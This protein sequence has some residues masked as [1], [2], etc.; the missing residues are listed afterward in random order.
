MTKHGS[1]FRYV[2]ITAAVIFTIMAAFS[3]ICL[4]DQVYAES[5]NIHNVTKGTTHETFDNA[6]SAADPG[7]VLE[8]TGDIDAEDTAALKKNL[9]LKLNGHTITSKLTS[10]SMITISSAGNLTVEGEGGSIVSAQR[11]A[12]AFY[13]NK[14]TLSISS[15]TLNGFSI[16]DNGG[17]IRSA[18]DLTIQ[19]STFTGNSSTNTSTS[20]DGRKSL[21]GGA[22]YQYYGTID[23]KNSIFD[24]NSAAECGVALFIR[25]VDKA[26]VTGCTVT[27]NEAATGGGMYIFQ[28]NDYKSVRVTVKDNVVDGN[29][30]VNT[31]FSG[32]GT[33]S[34][35]GGGMFVLTVYE[36]V[37]LIGNT[38]RNNKA[39]DTNRNAYAARGGGLSIVAYGEYQG[40]E[41]GGTVNITGGVIEGNE[42]RMGGG[43]D[44]S[45]HFMSPLRLDNAL[46]TGNSAVRGGGVWLCPQGSM[47][48]FS[49]LGGAVI[50]N[51][52]PED[53]TIKDLQ[54]GWYT[55]YPN[56]DDINHEG[57]DS[58]DLY[59]SGADVGYIKISKRGQGGV[60]VEWYED[61]SDNRSSPGTREFRRYKE[62]YRVLVSEGK[63]EGYPDLFG[64]DDPKG[65]NKSFGIHA[66][67]PYVTSKE[68]FLKELEKEAHLIIRNNYALRGGGIAANSPV[69]M[70][71]KD[72]P[73]RTLKVE[74]KWADDK[75]L[76]NEIRIDLV[77]YDTDE[78]GTPL[79]DEDGGL[80][81]RTLLDRDLVLSSDNDWSRTF[82]DLPYK[83]EDAEHEIH[84]CDYT[85]EEVAF[86]SFEGKVTESRDGD[87]KTVTLTNYPL[88]AISA[89]KL[90][91]DSGKEADRPESLTFIL[92]KYD[93]EKGSRSSDA[94]W[95]EAVLED[96]RSSRE[97]VSVAKDGS[98]S[99]SWDRLPEG[100]YRIIE[101]TDEPAGDGKTIADT[102]ATEYSTSTVD[103][104]KA[105]RDAIDEHHR[106]AGRTKKEDWI[107]T[108]EQEF[109]D[110][111]IRDHGLDP[112]HIYHADERDMEAYVEK[113]IDAFLL[114]LL[115]SDHMISE[116]EKATGV[117]LPEATENDVKQIENDDDLVHAFTARIGTI[118]VVTNSAEPVKP[119]KPDKPEP[120]KEK[121]GKKGAGADT[122]DRGL[123]AY[124][125]MMLLSA[126]SL[127]GLYACRRR[128]AG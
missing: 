128:R 74:K 108:L 27:A 24:G 88:T 120:E 23:V 111:Y 94:A 82:T 39:E 69:R 116:I 107:A 121:G 51:E 63:V 95:A 115:N 84:Y 64:V 5:G 30:A 48:S 50:Y 3:F 41:Y 44:Y 91:K 14:G 76:K 98:C 62:G 46:I 18:G 9:T 78:D 90:W 25:N 42:A 57:T 28:Q 106:A 112:D 81:N 87:T 86:V 54:Y 118:T 105:V 73:T 119:D 122:G 60:R 68:D 59:G 61:E 47:E 117:R 36:P 71:E 12:R 72:A 66:E 16:N 45:Q 124:L 43:I 101:K 127:G 15:T 65:T 21:G 97:T 2:V 67:A 80:L 19:D 113:K 100:E 114:D 89:T 123:G 17:A 20:S 35:K 96:G 7:D 38:I 32:S 6:F 49:T 34:G 70:G 13:N 4:N 58:I 11:G 103:V 85:I 40:T 55:L 8:L 22:V 75:V 1:L 83:Y 52:T 102:Y 53:V 10:G 37:E 92:Q 99:V 126:G 33:Y 79:Y 93:P 110:E 77:R 104:E 125:A 109:R 31:R 29:K 26:E 56:A